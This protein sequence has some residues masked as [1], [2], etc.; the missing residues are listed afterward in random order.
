MIMSF[1]YFD[2][3]NSLLH[4]VECTGKMGA[5]YPQFYP[6]T[7][8]AACGYVI[9]SANV[10]RTTRHKICFVGNGGS[11]A[12]ASHLSVDFQKRAGIPAMAFNDSAMLS[13]LGNDLGFRNTYTEQI[14]HHI[15]TNDV[16]ICISSS[17]MSANILEAAKEA[18]ILG[19]EVITFSGFSETNK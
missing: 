13:C 1:A 10:A 3:L 2:E 11:A 4:R 6:L 5:K 16:V 18:K 19:G 8:E 15:H 12:I 17:G 7:F 14:K 9:E